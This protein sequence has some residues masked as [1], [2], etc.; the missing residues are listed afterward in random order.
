MYQAVKKEAEPKVAS[1]MPEPKGYKLLISPVEVEEKTEGGVIMPD[2]IRDAEGIASII[3]YVVS[4]GPDAY[5]D[6]EKFPTGPWCKKGDFVIFRSYS[7]TRFKIHNQE[8]R[9]INDD[10]VEA[11][12]EDPRGYKRI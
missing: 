12:V 4:M 10:T 6:E 5:K 9:I 8:F 3:G 7:G 2:Q 1:K 11:V